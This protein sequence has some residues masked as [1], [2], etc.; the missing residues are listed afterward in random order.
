MNIKPQ[1]SIRV[2]KDIIFKKIETHVK[3]S[4]AQIF[5]EIEI[6]RNIQKF[7][8]KDETDSNE[9]THSSVNMTKY[10]MTPV[11]ID[12]PDTVNTTMHALPTMYVFY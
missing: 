7:V 9:I 8:K 4:K 6:K 3:H 11:S 2:K 5:P 10:L 1:S 12:I